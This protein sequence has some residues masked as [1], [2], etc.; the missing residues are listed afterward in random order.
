[1]A[2]CEVCLGYYADVD[3]TISQHDGAP[4]EIR[5]CR[6]CIS[7]VLRAMVQRHNASIDA[8]VAEFRQRLGI[9]LDDVTGG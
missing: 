8:E 9:G 2:G 4:V 6:G 5:F 3:V 1:M 7:A